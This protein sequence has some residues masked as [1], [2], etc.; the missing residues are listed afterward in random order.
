M[1]CLLFLFHSHE[2]QPR[3]NTQSIRPCFPSPQGVSNL[4]SASPLSSSPSSSPTQF[5]AYPPTNIASASSLT[6][7]HSLPTCDCPGLKSRLP[8]PKRR[9]MRA[10]LPPR[11]MSLRISSPRLRFQTTTTTTTTITTK[12]TTRPK[13]SPSTICTNTHSNLPASEMERT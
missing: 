1:T 13:N 5:T 3:Q 7:F 8:A 2:G 4:T 6:T 10:I 11:Q 12:M 9:M